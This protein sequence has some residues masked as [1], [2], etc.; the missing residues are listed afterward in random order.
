MSEDTVE[1]IKSRLD[2]E[3]VIKEYIELEKVGSNL[4]ALCP[5]HAEK[6]PSFFVSP[7]RQSWRCFG[8]CNDGGDMFDFVMK[9]EGV[10][11]YEALKI[12][13]KKAGVDIKKRDPKKASKKQKFSEM[14]DLATKF[15]Q[16][17]LEASKK[18]KEAKEY[19]IGRGISEE[20]INKW[21]LG[22][23]PDSWQALSKF[24]ISKGYKRKEIVEAG[25]AIKKNDHSY[26][27]FRGR[28]MFPINNPSANPI[29]FGGRIFGDN[30]DTAKYINSPQTPLYDK[31]KVLYGLDKAK[32]EIRRQDQ[33]ILVEGYTDVIMAHQAGFKNVISTSGTALTE[34]QLKI[35]SRYTHNLFTA[36]DM[37]DA[38]ASATK[39]GIEMARK[40]DFDVKVITLPNDMDPADLVKE[41]KS[42]WESAVENA[43]EI[44]KFYFEDAFSGRDLSKSKEK[45]KIAKELLPIIKKIPNRIE[46]SHWV[47]QLADKLDI[48][49]KAVSDQLKSIK[50]KKNKRKTAKNNKKREQRKKSRKAVLEERVISLV[51]KDPEKIGLIDDFEI[52][53]RRGKNILQAIKNDEEKDEK[54]KKTIDYFALRPERG[55]GN[56]KEEVKNCL[57]E[58]KKEKIKFK[59]KKIQ[60]EIKKAENQN[61]TEQ[62][63]KLTQE[64][65]KLSKKLQENS[66]D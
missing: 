2:I 51:A 40:L 61:N 8:G 21:R 13:A 29:A 57:K 17:Q 14:Y 22:Y 20:S 24:L 11:F 35:L 34:Q 6:T 54:M 47:K 28:I 58:I 27:R 37:D 44:M 5:F 32:V 64:A 12:L 3:D 63:K 7:S 56:E 19:L 65:Y 59:L 10:E 15:F 31:S 42:K 33:C 18:G 36:F 48:S 55:V 66:H 45:K 39:K 62:L 4:R 52:F 60:K 25:L 30:D 53:S 1:E 41:D 43:K 38:G 9:I 50:S 49:E 23:S 26:D 16:K 46:Q